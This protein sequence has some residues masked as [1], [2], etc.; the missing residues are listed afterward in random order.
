MASESEG[1]L[2]SRV[3]SKFQRGKPIKFPLNDEATSLAISPTGRFI[4][5]GFTD[6][7]VRIFDLTGHFRNGTSPPKKAQGPTV[8][9][10]SVVDSKRHQRYGAVACQIHAK[11]VHTTLR[12]DVQLSEDGLWCFAG[13]LRGSMELVAIYLGDLQAAY[14]RL[15]ES[16]QHDTITTEGDDDEGS[17]NLLDHLTVYR[18]Y[19]AKLRGFGAC[20]R[21]KNSGRYLLFTGKSIKNIHI[22]SFDPPTSPHQDP[23][24][25]QIYDCSTN[26]NTI[27]FLQFRRH[28][29]TGALQAISKSDDQRLRVWDLTAEE[30][31]LYDYDPDKR[32]NRPPFQDV[33]NTE[34]TL[35]V[36]GGFCV[37]GGS[38]MYNQTSL[39]SLNVENLLSPYNHT[40]MA[41]PGSSVS[42]V[43]G[44]RR[45]QR[46]DL[47]S[48]ESAY[49]SAEQADHVLLEI[50]DGKLA[51]YRA[52]QPTLSVMEKLPWY[53]TMARN[54]TVGRLPGDLPVAVLAFYQATSGKGQLS[55]WALEPPSGESF[56]PSPRA[57]LGLA[58]PS[59]ADETSLASTA[60][61]TP[62]SQVSHPTNQA[63]QLQSDS[64]S[65][66]S[67]GEGMGPPKPKTT[68]QMIAEP[69]VVDGLKQVEPAQLIRRFS[70]ESENAIKPN[71]ELTPDASEPASSPKTDTKTSGKLLIKV[72]VSELSQKTRN[73]SNR[74]VQSQSTRLPGSNATQERKHASLPVKLQNLENTKG[75]K[76]TSIF[77]QKLSR[78]SQDSAGEST[79]RKA[80]R[81]FSNESM[82]I[83][84][85]NTTHRVAAVA[86]RPPSAPTMSNEDSAR[87]SGPSNTPAKR[88]RSP[89][90]TPVNEFSDKRASST[91]L[92]KPS[93]TRPTAPNTKSTYPA[94][95]ETENQKVLKPQK[96]PSPP[97]RTIPD[98]Q[99]GNTRKSKSPSP[100]VEQ[101][102]TLL[103]S[104]VP[105][106]TER[107]PLITP[108][109]G[110][111]WQQFSVD[112]AAKAL[113]SLKH[114]PE[115]KQIAEETPLLARRLETTTAAP[116]SGPIHTELKPTQ[117]GREKG[118]LP[119]PW[120]GLEMFESSSAVSPPKEH[121]KK[122]TA[123]PNQTGPSRCLTRTSTESACCVTPLAGNK[124]KSTENTARETTEEDRSR[125][126]DQPIAKKPKTNSLDWL[127]SNNKLRGRRDDAQM[128]R[129][130]ASTC[131]SMRR[132]IEKHVDGLSANRATGALSRTEKLQA[133]HRAACVFLEKRVWRSVR[134]LLQSLERS[135]S[136]AALRESEELLQQLLRDYKNTAVRTMYLVTTDLLFA[137]FLF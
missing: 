73:A 106:V 124:R 72:S 97:L 108:T 74:D 64:K 49:G 33:P 67:T 96:P 86:G 113:S 128:R 12:M 109:P 45:M 8:P 2:S 44:T 130:I 55:V 53:S 114:S 5:A 37:C 41:L 104:S 1:V 77:N 71:K 70:N 7:T 116:V 47:R 28:S 92:S 6:G 137:P 59:K 13:V 76:E 3:L 26:G 112:S 107:R 21:L 101:G 57:K 31:G 35:A 93:A 90:T 118:R 81:R 78:L 27:R 117:N 36:V 22:W 95:R 60:A 129:S 58:S 9:R 121:A 62:E 11:G 126:L 91:M 122:A 17:A 25:T 111:A 100:L 46:G 24:L 88:K 48:V 136:I 69:M 102:K 89:L 4:C 39:V 82:D 40:E 43:G 23:V 84:D 105:K 29:T 99:N 120:K 131:L 125:S 80:A 32:P 87:V 85:K 83:P 110:K 52:G 34:A 56:A 75:S 135:P 115:A 61:T 20:M 119:E 14:Q 38:N 98:K 127:I 79:T 51:H 63:T 54:M 94:R 68:T 42:P 103:V 18:H 134:S 65:I 30:E 19:D 10:N 123:S 15:E 50:S 133:E 66:G 132:A 16:A